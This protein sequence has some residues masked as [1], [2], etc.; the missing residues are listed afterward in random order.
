MHVVLELAQ[1][2]WSPFQGGDEAVCP[3]SQVTDPQALEIG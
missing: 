3:V 2:F 1:R